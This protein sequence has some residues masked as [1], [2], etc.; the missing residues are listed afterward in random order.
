MRIRSLKPEFFHSEQVSHLSFGARILYEGMWCFADDNG[1]GRANT[2][3]L[4]AAIFPLDDHIGIEDVGQ[5]YNE[6]AGSGMVHAYQ[7]GTKD[8][9]H[10]VDWNENQSAAFR[11]GKPIHPAHGCMQESDHAALDRMQESAGVGSREQGE[12]SGDG[13]LDLTEGDPEL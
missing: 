8:Y 5:L 13:V 3:L 1:R 7:S 11:R 12:G 4:K 6:V 10:V 2:R 9:Y